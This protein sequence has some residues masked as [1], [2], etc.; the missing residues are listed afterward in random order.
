[1]RSPFKA[2]LITLAQ[3]NGKEDLIRENDIDR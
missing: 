3:E 1:M 2:N